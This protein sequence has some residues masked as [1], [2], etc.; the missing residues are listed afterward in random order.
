[1]TRILV[2]DDEPQIRRTLATNLRAGGFDVELAET[3]EAALAIIGAKPLDLVLLAVAE[4]GDVRNDRR[5]PHGFE[6]L[7]GES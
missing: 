4:H 1:M 3:G 6:R 2:V 5:S 7:L